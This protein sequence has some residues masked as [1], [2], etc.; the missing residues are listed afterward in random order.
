MQGNRDRCTDRESVL[1]CETAG[2]QCIKCDLAAPTNAQ[3]DDLVSELRPELRWGVEGDDR[4]LVHDREPVA[5]ALGLVE[6]V[7]REQD[8]RFRAVAEPGDHVEQLGPDPWVEPDG[9][10]VEEQ[11]LGARNERPC[12]LEAAPLAAAVGPGWPWEQFGEAEALRQILDS[13]GRS[14]LGDVPKPGM[15]LQVL[16]PG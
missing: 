16:P 1:T 8:R 14:Y 3:L 5:K 11:H 6:V 15:D 2:A 13:L 9:G 10:L 4:P 12:D 7:G